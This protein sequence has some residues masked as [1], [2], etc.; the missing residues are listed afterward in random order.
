MKTRPAHLLL[1][2]LPLATACACNANKESAPSSQTV[3]PSENSAPQKPL[4]T[5][6][7]DLKA[8]QAVIDSKPTPDELRAKYPGL[9]VV[10]PG[11]ITTRELRGD[12]SRFFAE[13]DDEGRVIGGKFQ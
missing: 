5:S 3:A 1:L 4:R 7:T 6:V 13:L 12:N 11:D 8:F 9:F 10:L 2:I